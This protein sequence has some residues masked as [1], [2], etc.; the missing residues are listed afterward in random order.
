MKVIITESKINR[1]IYHYLNSEYGNL[2]T[3]IS[4]DYPDLVFYIKKNTWYFYYDKR[5]N[6]VSVKKEYI[7]SFINDFF[8]LYYWQFQEI[9][10]DWIE[11]TYGL[12]INEVEVV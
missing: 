11:T 2:T 7:F 10:K 5:N 6:V 3:Y 4:K 12:E 9:I 8:N 1:V